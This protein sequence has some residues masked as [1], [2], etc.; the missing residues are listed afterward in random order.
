MNGKGVYVGGHQVADNVVYELVPS[1]SR[2]AGKPVGD[3][4]HGEVPAAVGRAGM[5]GVAVTVVDYLE[6]YRV[7]CLQPLGQPLQAGFG[8]G[9]TR[10]NG[11]TS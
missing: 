3:Y 6:T 1:Q 11:R 5:P 10:R 8:H 2:K 7:Q 4:D 9:R